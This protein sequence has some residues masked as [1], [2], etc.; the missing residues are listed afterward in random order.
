MRINA[1]EIIQQHDTVK[2]QAPI[3][4]AS[5]REYLWYEME[6]NYARYL[7]SKLDGFLVAVLPGAMARGEDIQVNGTV[8]ETLLYNLTNSY[9]HLLRGMQI[10]NCSM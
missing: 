10:P 1:P 8:S 9:M 2:I 7:T 4:H 5:G 3:E 6:G